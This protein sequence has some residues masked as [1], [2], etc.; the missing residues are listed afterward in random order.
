VRL[1]LFIRQIVCL[2][3]LSLQLVLAWGTLDYTSSLHLDDLGV[4][5]IGLDVLRIL[6]GSLL[7]LNPVAWVAAC[8]VAFMLG[9]GGLAVGGLTWRRRALRWSSLLDLPALVA[10]LSIVGSWLFVS[11]AYSTHTKV[12]IYVSSVR[13]TAVF[14]EFWFVPLILLVVAMIRIL[15]ELVAWIWRSTLKYEKL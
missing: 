5:F 14:P 15:P 3:L 13:F 9:S 1:S 2:L 11:L 7:C 8:G 12:L 10:T 4:T 6:F